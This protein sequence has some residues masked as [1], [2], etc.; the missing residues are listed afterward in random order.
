M[1]PATI[2]ALEKVKIFGIYVAAGI[3]LVILFELL[4]KKGGKKHD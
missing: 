3:A 2:E 1:N 4:C